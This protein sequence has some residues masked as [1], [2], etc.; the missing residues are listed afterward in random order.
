MDEVGFEFARAGKI[1]NLINRRTRQKIFQL[2]SK[3]V[4]IVSTIYFCDMLEPDG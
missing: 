2:F 1:L 3:K 4:W